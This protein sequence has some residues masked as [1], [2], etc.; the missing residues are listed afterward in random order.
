ML[1]VLHS[2]YKPI[3]LALLM[4]LGLA[5]GHLID[6]VLQMNLR[7]KITDAPPRSHSVVIKPQENTE[8]GLNLILQNNI[9]DANSRSTTA[10]MI[11]PSKGDGSSAAVTRVELKL[12]GTVVAAERSFALLEGNNELKIY[13]LGDKVPGDG[14]VEKIIRNQV[15]VR[16]R[17]QSLTTLLL[18]EKAP[19]LTSAS[20]STAGFEKSAGGGIRNV[21]KN[22]WRISRN[23]SESVRDNFAAQMRLVQMQPRIQSG[24][25]NGFMIQRIDSSSVLAQLGLKTGD[26]VVDV[27]NTRL[28]S[29]EKALQIVQQL[30]E[31]R[32]IILAVE[33]NNQPMSLSYEIQ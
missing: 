5:S 33:R 23:M 2:F 24:K 10:T 14:T 21:G 30:R 7:P 31:A 12:I 32:Q 20:H 13:H 18:L 15:Q 16:N 22:R 29:P 27:N 17:D 25:I 4:L 3:F 26:V 28:D 6:T 19:L 1:S 11:L 9:F 8:V